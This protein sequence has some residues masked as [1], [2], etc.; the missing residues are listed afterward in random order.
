[1]GLRS[2]SNVCGNC[3]LLGVCFFERF[4]PRHFS[5]FSTPGNDLERRSR[6]LCERR[7]FSRLLSQ[8]LGILRG[9]VAIFLRFDVALHDYFRCHPVNTI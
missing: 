9:S 6:P 2:A 5:A 4:A 3:V 1:M 8:P 7:S